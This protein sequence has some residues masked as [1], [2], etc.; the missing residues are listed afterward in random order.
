MG[1]IV[2][3]FMS[4]TI[5]SSGYVGLSKLFY[6]EITSFIATIVDVND[7]SIFQRT[8][9]IDQKKYQ[10]VEMHLSFW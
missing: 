9:I 8:K 7:T 3:Q 6:L 2:E 5:K 1:K 10:S 4:N